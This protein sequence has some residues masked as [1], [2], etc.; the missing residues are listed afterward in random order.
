[1]QFF[2]NSYA[3]YN[4]WR[5]PGIEPIPLHCSAMDKVWS[6][7]PS[8]KAN[9]KVKVQSVIGTLEEKNVKVWKMNTT[10][11]VSIHT[12]IWSN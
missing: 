7:F 10:E 3:N 8:F 1:M 2:E 5:Q 6:L 4:L 11:N 12:F 9:K